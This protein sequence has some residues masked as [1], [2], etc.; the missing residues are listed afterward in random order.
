MLSSVYFNA[1]ACNCSFTHTHLT[2]SALH[3]HSTNYTYLTLLQTCSGITVS[4]TA[5]YEA[6]AFCRV[7]PRK[8]SPKLPHIH[9]AQEYRYH[10]TR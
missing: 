7:R 4:I 10:E 5:Y 1:F 6:G 9:S 3:A 2:M 8:K